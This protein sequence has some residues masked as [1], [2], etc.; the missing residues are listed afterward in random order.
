VIL[1]FIF[2]I[3]CLAMSLVA[4]GLLFALASVGYGNEY[5]SD[6]SD[7]PDQPQEAARVLEHREAARFKGQL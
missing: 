6:S 4:V 1:L 5:A 3:G 7:L 2:L